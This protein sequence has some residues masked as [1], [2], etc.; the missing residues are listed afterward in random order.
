MLILASFPF[1][2][3]CC[4]SAYLPRHCTD[5]YLW[6]ERGNGVYQID[7]DGSG[8]MKPSYARCVFDNSSLGQTVVGHNLPNDTTVRAGQEYKDSIFPI[9]YR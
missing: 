7:V 2:M 9:S 8:P 1:D 6:K 5:L 4:V 3:I